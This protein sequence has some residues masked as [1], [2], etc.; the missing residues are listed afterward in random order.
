MSPPFA[1]IIVNQLTEDVAAQERRLHSLSAPVRQ[2]YYAQ[3]LQKQLD[4]AKI[5]AIGTDAMTLR[6]M[7][8]PGVQLACRRSKENMCWSI[9][10]PAGAVHAGWR[11][12][13]SC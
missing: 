6:R 13:M 8:R 11:I 2:G 5:G 9:F 4:D 1:L 3:I 12:P 7:I 10:G